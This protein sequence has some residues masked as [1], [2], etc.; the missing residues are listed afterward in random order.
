M[1]VLIVP[2]RV[3][4]SGR[5]GDTGFFDKAVLDP[6][7]CGSYASRI[8]Y[9]LKYGYKRGT[10][11]CKSSITAAVSPTLALLHRRTKWLSLDVRWHR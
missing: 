10:A 9:T 2:D 4:K 11:H 7:T 8:F 5:G 6:F 1:S 3:G